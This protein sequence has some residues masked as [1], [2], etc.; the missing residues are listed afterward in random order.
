MKGS[1]C[2][3][4]SQGLKEKT[5]LDKSPSSVR[6][7]VAM[8]QKMKHPF[9][10]LPILFLLCSVTVSEIPIQLLRLSGPLADRESEISGLAWKGDHLIFLP[11]NPER[12][13]LG[14]YG[15]LFY[16]TR[17]ELV[18]AVNSENDHDLLPKAIPFDDGGL[19][20][21]IPGYEGFEAITFLDDE[22][23]MTIEA[24]TNEGMMGY[25]VKGEVESGSGV[26]R[27]D[28]TT[29]REVSPQ[30]DVRNMTY[31]S[32]VLTGAGL[33]TFHEINGVGLNSNP[34]VVVYDF[35]LAVKPSLALEHLEYRITDATDIDSDGRFWLINYYWP[36]DE[37]VM[38]NKDP[39]AERFGEGPSH[40][41]SEA[42]ER[43]VEFKVENG[44][45]KMTNHPPIQLE[46]IENDS[47]NWEGIVR[48]GESGFLMVTDKYPTTIFAFVPISELDK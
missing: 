42:V 12:F 14:E 34:E 31:E 40:L 1:V 32:L 22:L 41:K 2:N 30:S 9:T 48:F 16:L 28:P 18:Q 25:L 46:L 6:F 27:L 20:S 35:E 26:I 23:F 4:L 37:A 21:N 7:A 45:V 5:L 47:R 15:S 3:A 8:T 43:L 44:W 13:P 10:I 24:K 36:G 11:E 33:M 19:L 29:L 17:S 39:L 38:S